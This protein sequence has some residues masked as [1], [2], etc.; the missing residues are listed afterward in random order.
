MNETNL[1]E[2]PPRFCSKVTINEDGCWLWDACKNS[3]GYGQFWLD[4]KMVSAHRY[5]YE[6]LVGPAPEGYD[7]DHFRNNP[8]PW[9]PC[10]KSCCN[11]AHLEAVTP[12]ENNRRGRGGQHHSLKTHCPKGHEYNE[13]NTYHFTTPRGGPNRQCRA[14]DKIRGREYRA[15]KKRN[16]H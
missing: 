7:L 12:R 5:S 16:L 1:S 14:C 13:E 15:R 2:L 4:G 9:K 8:G 3:N 10:S 11:P 6:K